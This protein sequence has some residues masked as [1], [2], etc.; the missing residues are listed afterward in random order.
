[1]KKNAILRK[2]VVSLAFQ[3]SAIARPAAVARLLKVGTVS[4]FMTLL[5]ACGG[6]QQAPQALQ[7]SPSQPSLPSQQTAQS[8]INFVLGPVDGGICGVFNAAGTKLATSAK[9]V[10]G[11]VSLDKVAT[12]S[13]M[14]QVSCEGGTYL[15]EASGK[16]LNAP[17]LRAYVDSADSLSSIVVTPVTEIASRIL[18]SGNL[19]AYKEILSK[20][21][22]AFGLANVKLDSVVP[23]NISKTA[24][25]N[26]EAG[27]YVA[28]LAALS[29]L[30]VAGA[31]GSDA[32]K[33]IGNL[34]ANFDAK[35][36]IKSGDV[37]QNFVNAVAAMLNNPLLK[38][39]LAGDSLAVAAAV[40]DGAGGA[41]PLAW[42]DYVNTDFSL[43]RVGLSQTIAPNVKSSIRLVGL[44]LRLD[45]RVTLGGKAC[46]LRDLQEVDEGEN[47]TVQ[48]EVVAD[49]PAVAAG[50]SELVI[51]DI[52]EQVASFTMLV[53]A[54]P[55]AAAQARTV[56]RN[57]GTGPAVVRGT[58]TA[59]APTVSTITGAHNYAAKRN[60]M[61][62]GVVVELL[63]AAAGNAVLMQTQTDASGNYSFSGVM[64]A[65]NV[66]VRVKAQLV[67]TGNAQ[68]DF[69]LRDNT[70]TTTPKALYTL[71][72][73]ATTVGAVETVV[74]LNAGHG[75]NDDGSVATTGGGRQS[76]PFSI[77]EVVYSAVTNL[78]AADANVKMAALNIYWSD[79]NMSTSGDKEKGLINTSHFAPGGVLPG[80]FIL[81][82]ADVD[83]DEFDQGVIGHELGH[84]LQSQL[85]YSDST[86]GSHAT[87][88]FK[89]ASLAYGE[90]YGTAIGGLLIGS[91]FYIDTSGA[92]QS[93]GGVTN[94]DLA[95]AAG[96]RKGFYSEESVGYVL[97]QIGKRHGF[98]PLWNAIVA[99][100]NGHESST[101][102]NFVS[103]YAAAYPGNAIDDLLAAENIRSKDVLGGLAA[104]ATP[105][106]AI[107]S[108]AS[109][110]AN[111]LEAVYLRLVASAP[112][113]D[114]AA[115]KASDDSA[116]FCFNRN[117]PGANLQNGLGM[118]KRFTFTAAYS[119]DMGLRFV[120]DAGVIL[121]TND[122]AV[123]TR[124]STGTAVVRYGWVDGTTQLEVIQ[125]R[126][127]TIRIGPQKPADVL[128]GNRCGHAL[129]L[130]RLS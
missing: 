117:L 1:M 14:V 39:R 92:R 80:L 56:P 71:D 99:M 48:E 109:A 32:D 84:Y 59:D 49:C 70:S 13:G 20:V 102:F 23:A 8:Q 40:F 94:L 65:A 9:T 53:Q 50:K 127:Y 93:A 52:D 90:G 103:R 35:L 36:H 4:A 66:I 12:G 5:F 114:G 43:T 6:S 45:L 25:P 2:D 54:A 76:A 33:V 29:Q 42:V 91:N 60:F 95:T 82:K 115:I 87:N 30:Q 124:D 11:A 123:D 110:G 67:S 46:R 28:V 79:R 113:Y 64:A 101:I 61:V 111:D 7:A 17:R 106:A 55:A 100:K 120:N 78:R 41:D 122:Y 38:S 104:G 129:S 77:L 24:F 47:E 75:F 96:L 88:D 51:V 86:G 26:S 69:S 44:D 74:N 97:Y 108:T 10:A 16:T 3:C 22:A 105:D 72:S 128:N 81:G 73:A 85:S 126:S 19:S 107:N 116:G 57:T 62:K 83:T 121:K 58:V 125:G 63:N 31:L 37:H 18:G 15:D 118:R 112:A 98:A 130:W 27:R 89:D 21:G 119:G 34:A 68:W